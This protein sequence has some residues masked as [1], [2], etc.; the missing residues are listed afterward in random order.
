MEERLALTRRAAATH[1]WFRG[2]RGYVVPAVAALAAGRRDLRILD[3]GCGTGDNLPWLSA[4]GQAT[5]VDLST[6]GVAATRAL[7]FRAARADIGRLPFADSTFDLATSFDVLQCVPHDGAAVTEMMRVVKPGGAVVLTVAALDALRGD[8]SEVWE[9]HQRYTRRSVRALVTGAGLVPER[10]S[11]L[12]ASLLP[13]MF[14]TR[15]AQRLTRRFRTLDPDSDIRVPAGPVNA[16]LTWLVAG[17]TA[18]AQRLPM[19][20][21]SSLL[22]VARKPPRA[23]R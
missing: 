10:V 4:Y 3:C 17:E 13:L 2:F 5:G 14:T 7:G 16:A 8:H 1:F 9:E 23:A 12:F 20:I 15:T 22:V 6:G 19:P 11:Y 18:V 21:G